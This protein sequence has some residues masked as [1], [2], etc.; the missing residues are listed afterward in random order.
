MPRTSKTETWRAS[1]G[2][3]SELFTRDL[4]GIFGLSNQRVLGVGIML[5][6]GYL[7]MD[8]LFCD[9]LPEVGLPET[10]EKRRARCNL[11]SN[12]GIGVFI[13]GGIVAWKG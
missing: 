3:G 13:L 10:D 11:L 5:G 1:R 8:N 6:G 2:A 4:D 12:V 9:G 7:M